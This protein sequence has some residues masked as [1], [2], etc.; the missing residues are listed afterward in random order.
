MNGVAIET[1]KEQ[2]LHENTIHSTLSWKPHI[3]NVCINIH[4]KIV[5]FKR[6]VYFLNEDI[7]HVL[8][9]IFITSF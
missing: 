3:N 9:C 7:K 8:T 4:R 6:I 2:K 5:L 1:V